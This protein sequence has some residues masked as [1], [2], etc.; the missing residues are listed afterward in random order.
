MNYGIEFHLYIDIV[1][2]VHMLFVK[3]LLLEVDV[4]R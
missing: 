3:K 2:I 4:R 1:L